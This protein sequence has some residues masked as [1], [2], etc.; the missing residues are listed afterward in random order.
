MG[1]KVF[2]LYDTDQAIKLMQRALNELMDLSLACDGNFGKVTQEAVKRFQV[3]VGVSETDADGAC[4]GPQLQSHLK[5][6]IETKYLGEGDFTQAAQTLGCELA[7]VKAVALTEAKEFGFFDDGF[8]VILFERHKFYQAMVKRRGV[9]GA[10]SLNAI[11]SDICNKDAGGYIG[12]TREQY[13]LKKAAVLDKDAAYASA[14]W[15]MFQ[16]MGSNHL[17]AG[18]PTVQAFVDAMCDSEG[19]QLQAFVSFI[20]AD[21]NLHQAL[22][23]KDW[24]EFAR[25]YNGPAYAKNSY[26]KKM[27]ENYNRFRNL[28]V[29]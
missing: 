7:A 23:N 8:P 22:K 28:V 14:S 29:S 17:A 25:R 6:L 27:S 12:G 21:A 9:G 3:T 11:S 15:G 16:I 13:R 1:E 4:Y 2:G 19:K 10:D 20:K 5:Q 18:Y 24:A 26:D